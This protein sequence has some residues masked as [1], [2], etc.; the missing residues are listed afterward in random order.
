LLGEVDC[1]DV[2]LGDRVNFDL[3]PESCHCFVADG[4]ALPRLTTERERE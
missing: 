1:A 3:A 2:R 4:S